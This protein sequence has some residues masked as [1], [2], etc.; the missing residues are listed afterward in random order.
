MKY[1]IILGDGMADQPIAELGGKTPL[2]YARTPAL[3][4]IS[5]KAEIGM[6]QTIP[7]GMNPGSDTANLAVLGYNPKTYYTGRSPLEA[8]SIGVPMSDTDIAIRC[9]IVTLSEE[10]C[11]YEERTIVD[12][13]AGEISTQE[14]AELIGAVREVFENDEFSYFVGTSYRHLLIWKQGSVVELTPPHDV[15]GQKIGAYLPGQEK[16]REMMRRSFEILNNHPVNLRRAELGLNKANSLWFW[17][18]GTK[19]MLSGFQNKTGKKGAMISAVDL[20]KG[21]AVGAGMTNIEVDGAD[22]TLE[23]NYE[24]KAKAAVQALVSDGFDFV[25][26]HVEA[27]DEMGHQGSYERKVKAIEYLDQRVIG[28]VKKALDDADLEYRMLVMPD[29][30]TPICVRTHTSDP[31]PYLLFDSTKPQSHT[32]SYN[33]REAEASGI[34]V[35]DGYELLDILLQN[36]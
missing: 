12:H 7:E 28:P 22:G 32:W 18:A 14:A 27:P 5:K 4:A 21:I 16:L 19:P 34:Y 26:V 3:D 31:V 25:Y 11:A 8:L 23:T 1:M 29:H 17:G 15:L 9:N 20:L 30:P 35:P 6:V 33:E 2:E 36:Q 13:S 24:G 10:N